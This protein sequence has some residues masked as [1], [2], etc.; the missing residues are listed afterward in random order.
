MSKISSVYAQSLFEIALES[1]QLQEFQEDLESLQQVFEQNK[2]F[3][4]VPKEE[5]KALL[6]QDLEKRVP[7][8]VLHFLEVLID[9][10]RFSH[11][12]EIVN[13]FHYLVNDHFQIVE[14][15][16]KTPINLEAEQLAELAQTFGKKL[17]KEVRVKVELD[18]TLIGGYQIRIGDK[19]Y[20]NSIKM[21]LKSLEK[22]LL[23]G[24]TYVN[25]T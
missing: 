2:V 18:P 25:Q 22:S 9:N 23:G 15:T 17:N 3:A 24:E 16:V 21:K 14:A 19:I 12:S 7:L 13:D 10:G 4:Q 20:D 6:V 1:D 8:D 11:L 5:Q